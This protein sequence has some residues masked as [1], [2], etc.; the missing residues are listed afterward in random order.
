[1]NDFEVIGCTIYYF[2]VYEG[3][4]PIKKYGKYFKTMLMWYRFFM[5]II[6]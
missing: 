3:V 5:L 6:Y 4:K 1:M 2:D